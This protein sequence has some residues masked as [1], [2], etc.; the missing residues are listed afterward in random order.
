MSANSNDRVMTVGVD[1]SEQSLAAL[2]WAIAQA[3]HYGKIQPVIS[4]HFPLRHSPRPA[5]GAPSPNLKNAFEDQA[6]EI[7]ENAISG[8]DSSLLL[9]SRVAHGQPGPV[10]VEM[11]AESDLLVV[12]TRGH[13]A[14]V[15]AL[16]GSTSSYCTA[17]SDVPV[18]VIPADANQARIQRIV[19]G[20]DS[21]ASS[22][23][24][25]TWALEHRP[26]GAVV[27]A[28]HSW[29]PPAAGLG[30]TATPYEI[31]ETSAERILSRAAT[32]A[33]EAAGQPEDS[34]ERRLVLGDPRG[35]LRDCEADLLV[36]GAR[37]EGVISHLL[38]GSATTALVN[39]PRIP[40]VVVPGTAED[41]WP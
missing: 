24:A 37:G 4:W 2:A 33:A 32:R 15:G 5:P 20:V 11:A 6:K 36:L 7:V 8:I 31:F 3:E 22:T 19:V 14:F 28:V 34:V 41:G 17:H 27:Q 23:A 10:L 21:S 18:A 39:H 35:S 13:G 1:G 40:T 38:L 30:E 12:G 25:L 26:E 9:P 16:L 29:S